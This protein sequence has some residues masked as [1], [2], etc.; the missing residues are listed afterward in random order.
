MYCVRTP[1][2]VLAQCCL[3]LALLL[4]PFIVMAGLVD[5]VAFFEQ[6]VREVGP[7]PWSGPQEQ[8]RGGGR[9]PTEAGAKLAACTRW[10]L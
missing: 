9:K 1:V 5:S 4:R 6:R 2:A 3:T 10:G 8:D 7:W